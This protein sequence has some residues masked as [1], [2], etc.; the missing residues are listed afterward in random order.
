LPDPPEFVIEIEDDTVAEPCGKGYYVVALYTDLITEET[1][2]TGSAVQSWY[3]PN[4][5]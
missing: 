3:S 1:K 4:C 5:S 2:E